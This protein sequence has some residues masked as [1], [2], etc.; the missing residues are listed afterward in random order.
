M[1]AQDFKD[2]NNTS[3][4]MEC[5]MFLFVCKIWFMMKLQNPDQLPEK[6]VYSLPALM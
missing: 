6:I 2:S 4:N 3:L 5:R 1:C